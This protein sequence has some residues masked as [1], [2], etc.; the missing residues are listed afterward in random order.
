[1]ASNGANW[2]PGVVDLANDITTVATTPVIVRGYVVNTVLSAH[3]CN[4]NNGS[5]TLF[6]IP[7]STAAGTVVEFASN[8]GVIFDTNLIVDPDN[9]GTGSITILYKERIR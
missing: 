6:I 5:T 4:I 7:A 1:M 2:T 9:S 3:A 8:D